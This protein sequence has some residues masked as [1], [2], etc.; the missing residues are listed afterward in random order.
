MSEE[1]K[2]CRFVMWIFIAMEWVCGLLLGDTNGKNIMA[3]AAIA[4]FLTSIVIRRIDKV[5]TDSNEKI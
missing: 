4:S 5:K 1:Y 2:I 3:I